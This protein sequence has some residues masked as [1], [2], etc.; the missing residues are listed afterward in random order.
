MKITT[1]ISESAERQKYLALVKSH[2]SHLPRLP[3][4][5][6][7][8]ER[9]I[10]SDHPTWGYQ[11]RISIAVENDD[12]FLAHCTLMHDNREQSGIGW[13]GFFECPDEQVVFDMLWQRV[14]Q[15]SSA[16]GIKALRGPINGTIWY[17]YRFAVPG[18]TSIPPFQGELLCEDYYHRFFEGIPNHQ[19]VSYYSAMRENFDDLIR[20]TLPF[21]ERMLS[22]SPLHLETYA[23]ISTD[24]LR[25]IFNLARTVFQSSWG[26]APLSDEELLSYYS[27]EKL[28]ATLFKAYILRSNGK[29]IGFGTVFREDDD[30]LVLKTLALDPAFQGKGLGN[31]LIHQIHRDAQDHCSRMVY[32]L[33]RYENNVK[34]LPKDGAVVFREY[35]AFEI[36][37]Q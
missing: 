28:K 17:S 7:E 31:A 19:E 18:P 6:G 3:L 13:F 27:Q 20:I 23:E 24:V 35:S 10:S 14:K 5:F 11:K 21:H 30:T 36:P 16:M 29:L 2:Y 34:R 32:A 9:L 25:E 12:Q 37:V 33:I 22:D 4:H 26:Y 1:Y 15:E 8:I